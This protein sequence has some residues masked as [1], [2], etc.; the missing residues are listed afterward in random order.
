MS[1]VRLAHIEA[2][3]NCITGVVLAQLVLWA[4]GVPLHEA[5]ALNVV[6][7]LVSYVRSFVLRMIFAVLW[8]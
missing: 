5:L 2:L 4:F 7:I 3:L 1:D 8:R 6:M